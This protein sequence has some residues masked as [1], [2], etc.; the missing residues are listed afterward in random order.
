MF[1]QIL[2]IIAGSVFVSYGAKILVEGSSSLAKRLNISDLVIGLTVVSLG[3]SSPELIVSVLAARSGQADVALGNVIGSNLMNIC[4]IL[5]LAAIIRPLYI[6][7]NTV[8]KEIPLSLL[9]IIVVFLMSND[10]MIDHVSP[11]VISRIDGIVL[12]C[13]FVIYLYYMLEVAQ[14]NPE[15]AVQGII[16]APVWQ[17]AL[18]VI[19]GIVALTLGGRFIVDSAVSLAR[20]M[21]ISEAV[22]G[23]TLVAIG[24]SIPELA[25]S[26]VAARK[27]NTDI[28]VGNV[29]GSNIF[30]VFLI[31]GISATVAPLPLGNITSLDF[32]VCILVTAMLF[33]F[34]FFRTPRVVTRGK[35]FAFLAVY[36]VYMTYLLMHA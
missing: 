24:T 25:T 28:A 14:N 2:I 10:Q 29:I 9:G 27:G 11:S 6:R 34:C 15:P 35:G 36:I 31:L 21:G 26:L 16:H 8:W 12:L 22:I 17:A 7:R 5:G 1:L 23:L 32:A 13:F 33:V 3:T 19:A 20:S 30:N 18:K 4:L